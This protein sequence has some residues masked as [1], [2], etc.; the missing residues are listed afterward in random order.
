ML[1]IADQ[2]IGGARVRRIFTMAGRVMR[3]GD[4]LTG[5]EVRA[6]PVANRRALM[7]AQYIEVWPRPRE[8]DTSAMQRFIVHRPPGKFDVVAGARIN[9]HPLSRAEAEELARS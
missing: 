2:D 5:D 6:L 8:A 1:L 7:E 9:E 3:A 4:E